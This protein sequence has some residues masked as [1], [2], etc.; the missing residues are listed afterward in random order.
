MKLE[1]GLGPK[2]IPHRLVEEWMNNNLLELH[3]A[4]VVL[5]HQQFVDFQGNP[6]AFAATG[7]LGAQLG[8]I[9]LQV[10]RDVG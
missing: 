10:G 5:H 2:K 9:Q 4:G 8:F 6:F 3:L 1:V 7:A